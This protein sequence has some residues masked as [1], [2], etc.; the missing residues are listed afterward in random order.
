M[1][2][3][4]FPSNDELTVYDIKQ[5]ISK[6]RKYNW[7]LTHLICWIVLNDASHSNLHP[8]RQTL[9]FNGMKLESDHK[10]LKY[11]DA[12]ITTPLAVIHLQD[13][14]KMMPRI[15]SK[16]LVNSGPPILFWMFENYHSDI[17]QF[18]EGEEWVDDHYNET[19][20]YEMG[21]CQTFAKWM[22][23]FHFGKNIFENVF[24][25]R[26]AGRMTPINR[27]IW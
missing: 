17:Y 22:I 21:Q 13:Q 27:T 7:R 19:L 1:V 12:D 3:D 10:H 15:I 25:H 26:S 8:E 23:Y 2:D 4:N 14:G 5:M 18:M 6:T 16:V 24:L 11:Y 20:F 9:Y